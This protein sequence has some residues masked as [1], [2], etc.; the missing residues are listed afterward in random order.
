MSFLEA[1]RR[2]VLVSIVFALVFGLFVAFISGGE[3]LEAAF[4]VA[5]FVFIV[6]FL[7]CLFNIFLMPDV[8]NAKNTSALLRIKARIYLAML[9][10][11]ELKITSWGFN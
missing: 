2:C 6:A 7:F 3:N 11:K 9:Y 8:Q 5:F 4:I 1:L 10:Q